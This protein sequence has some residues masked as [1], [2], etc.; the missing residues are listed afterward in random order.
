MLAQANNHIS[1]LQNANYTLNSINKLLIIQFRGLVKQNEKIRA[2][3]L[4]RV[5]SASVLQELVRHG[6]SPSLACLDRESDLNID[7]HS[8]DNIGTLFDRAFGQFKRCVHRKEYVYKKALTKKVLLGIHSLQTASMV[9]EFG[10]GWRKVDVVILNNTVY[11]IKSE[12]DSLSRLVDQ[13]DAFRR[14]F[15]MVNVIV[16][17]NH[18]RDLESMIS[19]FVG[20][21]VL[22]DC[23]QISTV[24]SAIDDVARSDLE[25]IFDTI[26]QKEAS[27]ILRSVGKLV[28]ESLYVA[29]VVA[30]LNRRE[31]YRMNLALSTPICEAMAWR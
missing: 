22:S 26:N 15:A 20:I 2:T 31:L 11:E 16:G 23:D 6:C 3:A 14:V 28:P 19:S 5:F 12:R 1:I 30:P 8:K 7:P 29:V 4:A 25:A 27:I 9:T 13:I 10:V 17:E 18:P 21:M 24:R